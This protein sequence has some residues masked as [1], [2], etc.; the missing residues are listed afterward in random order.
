MYDVCLSIYVIMYVCIITFMCTYTYLCK[1][2]LTCVF[3]S[4]SL[5]QLY[6]FLD[7]YN[8]EPPILLDLYPPPLYKLAGSE[9]LEH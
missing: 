1:Y 8:N 2:I 5:Y 6:L 4:L 9:C 3:V 7:N